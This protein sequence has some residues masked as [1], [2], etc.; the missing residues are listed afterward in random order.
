MKRPS[1]TEPSVLKRAS[2]VPKEH[3]AH[4]RFLCHAEVLVESGNNVY[5]A[6]LDDFSVAGCRLSSVGTLGIVGRIDLL[7]ST[8]DGDLRRVKGMVTWTRD[9]TIGV[10]LL[11][12]PP[13]LSVATATP[14]GTDD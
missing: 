12:D 10:R 1:C 8:V 14:L 13:W 9:N 6:W 7:I 4:R 2:T 3:R 11:T 5:H